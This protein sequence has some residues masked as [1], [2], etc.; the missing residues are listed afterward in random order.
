MKQ[1]FESSNHFISHK[2]PYL[3]G[4]LI[5]C[6][7]KLYKVACHNYSVSYRSVSFIIIILDHPRFQQ[8]EHNTQIKPYQKKHSLSTQVY[9]V[10]PFCVSFLKS[11]PFYHSNIPHPLPSSWPQKSYK[12]NETGLLTSIFSAC[13]WL[14]PQCLLSFENVFY[15][16]LGGCQRHFCL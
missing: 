9:A 2:S 3:P 13:R 10:L 8:E 7:C 1:Y 12:A 4:M 14:H 5:F 15:P 16:L 6:Q 11:L